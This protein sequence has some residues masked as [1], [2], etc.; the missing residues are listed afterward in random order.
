ME[1]KRMEELAEKYANKN[2]EMSIFIDMFAEITGN[3]KIGF[4]KAYKDLKFAVDKIYDLFVENFQEISDE[5]ITEFISL[6]E[7][8]TKVV[9]DGTNKIEIG[10][11]KD[12]I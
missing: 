6:C 4:V 11:N 2:K 10:G 3:K 1:E 9:T 5:E 7:E 12:G 8:L